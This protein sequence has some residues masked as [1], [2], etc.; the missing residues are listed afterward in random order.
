MAS[1]GIRSHCE[2]LVADPA[3][4]DEPSRPARRLLDLAPE[5]RDVDVARALVADVR[6]VP[7]VLHDLAPAVDALGLLREEREQAELRGG[8]ADRPPVDPDVVP[9]HVEL[10]RADSAHGAARCAVELAAA[11]DRPLVVDD[12][13]PLAHAA[14]TRAARSVMRTVVPRRGADS[15]SSRAPIAS[16]AAATI[17]SPSPKPPLASSSPR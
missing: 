2:E 10:E 17:A 11:Q 1:L 13:D 3:H 4:G 6:A 8:Q 15:I 14:R 7:E 5:V 12:E 16:A 9:V